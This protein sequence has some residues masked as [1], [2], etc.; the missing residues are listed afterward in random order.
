MVS[1]MPSIG[2]STGL[3]LTI[4]ITCC[5][6]CETWLKPHIDDRFCEISG[7]N[8]RHDRTYSSRGDGI[9]FNIKQNLNSKIV[10]K[11][12]D[13]SIVEYLAVEISGNN[14]KCVV[15]CVYNPNRCYCLDY[16]FS[17]LDEVSVAYENIILCGDFN[18]VLVVNDV[19]ATQ[20][21]DSYNSISN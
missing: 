14:I 2:V 16:V 6:F 5:V 1:T 15:M 12:G 7:F 4:L 18:V 17:A 20:L 13:D 10:L 19:R 9:A 3:K 21:R 8:V 11:S